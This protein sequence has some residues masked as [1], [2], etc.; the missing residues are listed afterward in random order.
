LED[1]V[2][3]LK[4]KESSGE[5]NVMGELL[6][7]LNADTI[8]AITEDLSEIKTTV[9]QTNK[10]TEKTLE[11]LKASKKKDETGMFGQIDDKKNKGKIIDGVSNFNSSRSIGYWHGI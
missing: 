9:K 7:I 6:N 8:K 1:L 11:L 5:N 10:N 4:E 3:I 2:E